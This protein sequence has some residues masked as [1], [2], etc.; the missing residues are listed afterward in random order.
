MVPT[1]G[2]PISPLLPRFILRSQLQ[3][4]HAVPRPSRKPLPPRFLLLQPELRLMIYD[5]LFHELE[6]RGSEIATLSGRPQS[7]IRNKPAMQ[8]NITLITPS[9]L[10]PV[11]LT[12][13]LVHLE[14]SPLF[15]QRAQVLRSTPARMIMNVHCV[16]DPVLRRLDRSFGLIQE[17]IETKEVRKKETQAG[18]IFR[19]LAEVYANHES[20]A[21]NKAR[22]STYHNSRQAYGSSHPHAPSSTHRSLSHRCNAGSLGTGVSRCVDRI[23]YI[24]YALKNIHLP[25]TS[26]MRACDFEGLEFGKREIWLR[27]MTMEE[28]RGDKQ[29][30]GLPVGEEEWKQEW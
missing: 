29:R 8:M 4:R 3:I 1:S 20:R 15:H 6:I 9:L 21:P 14:V 12:S 7:T 17:A 24:N 16:N 27:D 23:S 11:L 10:T 2:L 13:H 19:S 28:S 22:P 25:A 26:Q 30:R 5:F 18:C